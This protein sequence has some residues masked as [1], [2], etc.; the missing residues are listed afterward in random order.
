MERHRSRLTLGRSRLTRG[1]AWLAIAPAV[2]VALFFAWPVAAIV[3]RGLSRGG[4]VDVVRDRALRKVAWFTLWQAVISTGLTVAAGLPLAFVLSRYRFTG[5]RFVESAMIVPFVLPTVAVGAAYRALLPGRLQQSVVA[6]VIAHVFFNVAVVVRTITPLWRQVDQRRNDAA[7]TLGATPLQVVRTVTVPFLAPALATAASIVFLFTFTSFGVVLLLG[8]PR[9]RTI[10]VEIFQR[11]A[12]QL[13]LRTASALAL[14]QLIALAAA[15]TATNRR[16]TT[17]SS[18]VTENIRPT[19]R[20]VL[21]VVLVVAAVFF[22]APIVALATRAGGWTHAFDTTARHAIQRSVTTALVAALIATTLGAMASVAIAARARSGGILNTAIVLPLGTSAV[23]VGFGLLITFNRAPLDLR[24]RW[25]MIPIAHALIGLPFV[26]RTAVPVLRAIDPRQRDAAAT[27]GA[28]AW[29]TWLTIDAPRLRHALVVGF[30][31][32]FSISLGEFG[33]SSFLAR[34]T[35]PTLPILIGELLG[36]PGGA[37]RERAYAL[38]LV[39]ATVT[40]VVMI[41]VD[42]IGNRHHV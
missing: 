3:V 32:S 28:S 40:A 13:D 39:L 23:T 18:R 37:V 22:L 15:L 17:I 31:F 7:A 38:A 8:G 27:L 26:V 6:I 9:R 12:Q 5:R 42:R 34:R 41:V 21:A 24:G 25:M 4:V 29:R 11:M 33:A 1:R 16:A 35:G 2:F 36:K 30:G 20:G 14:V 19:R 10:E